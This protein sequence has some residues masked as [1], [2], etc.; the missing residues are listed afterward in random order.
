L[1]DIVARLERE[2]W[3]EVPGTKH[4]QF[5]A[6]GLPIERSILDTVARTARAHGVTPSVFIEAALRDKL[7]AV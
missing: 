6:V 5:H 2:G 1:R 4:A 7:A 3:R